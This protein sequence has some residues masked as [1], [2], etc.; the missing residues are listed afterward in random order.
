M[1]VRK[2]KNGMQLIMILATGK[3]DRKMISKEKLECRKCVK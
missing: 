1:G 2:R 3:I